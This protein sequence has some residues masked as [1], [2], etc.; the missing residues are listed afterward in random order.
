MANKSANGGMNVMNKHSQHVFRITALS[1]A[2]SL[3]LAA[4]TAQA[5]S[6]S[7]EKKNMNR[8][9]HTDLQGRP[10][11]QPNVISIPTA[12]DAVRQHS[13]NAPSG[14]RSTKSA[15]SRQRQ[16]GGRKQ[17]DDDH[18]VSV[19]EIRRE[20]LKPARPPAVRPQM[21]RCAGLAVAGWNGRQGLPAA[22]RTGEQRRNLGISGM[23]RY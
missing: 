11:Y 13:G 15:A 16:T 9:G 10:S 12:D 3:A 7:G 19:R 2:V 22:Q 14:Y 18:D 6:Q 8:V 20:A 4:G 1:I 17:R 23:G 21:T 5:I